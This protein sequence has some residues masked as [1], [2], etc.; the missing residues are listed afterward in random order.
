[1][2]SL[3]RILPT[4]KTKLDY[5]SE[6]KFKIKFDNDYFWHVP[7]KLFPLGQQQKGIAF[8]CYLWKHTSRFNNYQDVL[9]F[10][11]QDHTSFQEEEINHTC[12]Q[13][14]PS[15][16]LQV[17]PVSK[18]I[19]LSNSNNNNKNPILFPPYNGI[20]QQEQ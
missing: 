20:S 2:K 6:G 17:C 12:T 11:Q 7:A 19:N 16:M 9:A 4:Q 8:L 13:H 10:P 5:S 1:M 18:K 14:L 3:N 15:S